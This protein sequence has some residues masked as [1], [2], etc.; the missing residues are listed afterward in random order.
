MRE[1]KTIEMHTCGEPA[2]I[3][4]SG[5]PEL[6]GATMLEKQQDMQEHYDH[7]RTAVIL[8]PRGH[9]NMF[10]II[11]TAPCNSQ[12]DFG[13]LFMN[14]VGYEGMCGHGT[15]CLATA[16]VNEKWIEVKEPETTMCI[17]TVTGLVSVRI[18]VKE[19]KA[20]SVTLQNVPSF[21]Y[22]IDQPIHTDGYGTVKADIVF[23]GNVFA[24]VN[25][26][27][28]SVEL[29]LDNL[30]E[31]IA[32]AMDVLKH[33]NQDASFQHPLLPISK[34]EFI[35]LYSEKNK[36]SDMEG[37]NC[38]IF[39]GE[40][41]DRSPCGTGTCARVTDLYYRN[42]LKLGEATYHGNLMGQTFRGI[43]VGTEKVGDFTATRVEISGKAYKT[44]S[45][46]FIIDESDPLTYGFPFNA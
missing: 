41:I 40:Q 45:C 11:L 30:K 7:L 16:A 38:I 13:V 4:I 23:S 34:I 37:N 46:D 33:V 20:Q 29:K 17:D 1:I 28:L 36:S 24:L 27:T 19:G 22:S 9:Q 42:Q 10:G 32:L 31:L 8:E 44:G 6:K 18:Q 15:I 21:V 39:E 5:M 3:V 25:V 26:D 2:R 43:V 14:G 35:L 12:A